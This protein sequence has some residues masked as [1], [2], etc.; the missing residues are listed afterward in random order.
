MAG[1]FHQILNGPQLFPKLKRLHFLWVIKDSDQ[2]SW[3]PTW[4]HFLKSA[5]NP[6]FVTKNQPENLDSDLKAE[7]I[8]ITV[9]FYITNHPRFTSRPQQFFTYEDDE[10]Q[11]LFESKGILINQSST[12]LPFM[13]PECFIKK[14]RPDFQQT[15]MEI[16]KCQKG[17]KRCAVF[18]CGPQAMVDSI[19]HVVFGE[20]WTDFQFDFHKETFYF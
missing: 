13:V 7:D 15:L 11:P 10:E 4:S 18:T 12:D 16:K 8:E 2:I 9:E 20:K 3:F 6:F 1:I 14:G 5:K 17:E 19:E